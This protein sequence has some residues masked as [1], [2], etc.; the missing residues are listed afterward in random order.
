[1]YAIGK[2]AVM[3]AASL[4]V[5]HYRIAP[6]D[7][8]AECE[9]LRCA[10]QSASL[11]L[12]HMAD[13]LPDDAPR[14]LGPLLSV[15]SMLL[16]DPMLYEQTCALITERHYNAEWALTAQGQVLAEQFAAMED[17]YL[18]ER[19]ADIRQVIERVLRVLS[20]SPPLL[21]GL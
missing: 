6:D 14:E 20:G 17:D 10:L 12:Q 11:D 8:S 1:G 2:A 9:R 18:R 7:T 4:E 21:A 19:A 3:G 13:A 5:E 16:D 15:H